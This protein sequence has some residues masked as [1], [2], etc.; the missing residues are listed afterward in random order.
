MVKLSH[1]SELQEIKGYVVIERKNAGND[2]AKLNS[3][4][5]TVLQGNKMV[6][7]CDYIFY[8]TSLPNNLLG[9]LSV[10]CKLTSKVW[11]II[12]TSK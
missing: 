8:Q 3:K 4:L 10:S 7:F 11:L 6:T 9:N 5:V 2:L 1:R 12:N